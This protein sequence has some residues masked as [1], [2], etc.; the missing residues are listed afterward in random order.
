ML[1]SDPTAIP[2]DIGTKNC[3]YL[4]GKVPFITDRLQRNLHAQGVS[5]VMIQ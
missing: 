1:L 5:C 2:G 4:N 3:F